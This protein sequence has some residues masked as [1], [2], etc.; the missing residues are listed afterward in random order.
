M[1]VKQQRMAQEHGD[2]DVANNIESA[3]H[4]KGFC[5]WRSGK[6]TRK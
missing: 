5:K 6:E 3:R 4:E 1:R 2:E